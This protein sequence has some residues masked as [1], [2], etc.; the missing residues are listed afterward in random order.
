M[1]KFYIEYEKH[2]NYEK[3]FKLVEFKNSFGKNEVVKSPLSFIR[4]YTNQDLYTLNKL[5]NL[6]A[7]FL[8]KLF[9]KKYKH[10]EYKIEIVKLKFKKI[11]S[12]EIKQSI[13]KQKESVDN[14]N[15]DNNDNDDENDDENDDDDDENYDENVDEKEDGYDVRNDDENVDEYD[16][17]GNFNHIPIMVELC[18]S[19]KY[20][21]K[22][23]NSE[24]IIKHLLN[25]IKCNITNNNPND[26]KYILSRNKDIKINFEISTFNEIEHI[27]NAYINLQKT[28]IKKKKSIINMYYILDEENIYNNNILF[29]IFLLI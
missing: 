19:Y 20:N 12:N 27:Y 28:K 17:D 15:N 22:T 5:N 4:K 25:C 7:I 23:T 13:K 24:N 14:K 1:Q 9:D 29:E 3:P 10:I 18:D 11:K 8:L 16:D 26:L 2:Y 6:E 21:K